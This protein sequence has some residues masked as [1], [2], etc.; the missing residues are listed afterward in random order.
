RMVLKLYLDLCVYNRPFDYQGQERVA[1]ETSAFIYLLEKV[2][3]GSYALRGHG[4][5]SLFLTTGG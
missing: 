5:K 1:L 2:E 4:V 3:K